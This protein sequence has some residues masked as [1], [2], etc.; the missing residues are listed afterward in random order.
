LERSSPTILVPP[1]TLNTN[2]VLISGLTEVRKT[3][4][5]TIRESAYGKSG[6]IVLLGTLRPSVGPRK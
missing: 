2:G 4:R 3:P 6:L 1:E 5:V